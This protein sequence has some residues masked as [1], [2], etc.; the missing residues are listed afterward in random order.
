MIKSL[1]I[2]NL[3]SLTKKNKKRFLI[4]TNI[5]ISFVV[6]AIIASFVSISYENKLIKL[7]KDLIKL[8]YDQLITQEWLTDTGLLLK[9]NS[10]Y[11]FLYNVGGFET[12]KLWDLKRSR[13]QFHVLYWTP[14][15]VQLALS[16]AKKIN[17]NQDLFPQTELDEIKKR[18]SLI[19]TY[20]NDKSYL[21]EFDL[22]KFSIKEMENVTNEIY[23]YVSNTLN[24]LKYYSKKDLD[25]YTKTNTENTIK[26]D[27]KYF[28]ENIESLETIEHQITKLGVITEILNR[29]YKYNNQ[30]I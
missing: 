17:L 12:S 18:Y 28:S 4:I 24:D 13:F 11:E 26:K 21:K 3:L 22:K 10:E 7:R 9:R 20:Y 14:A 29:L 16:D 23:K 19:S 8:N 5:A 6:A 2:N 27:E 1:V 25:Y 15:T 30:S